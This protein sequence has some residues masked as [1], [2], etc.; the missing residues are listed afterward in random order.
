MKKYVFIIA[1]VFFGILITKAQDAQLS[2]FTSSPLSINPAETGAF[3]GKM[4]LIGNYRGQ[5][6]GF[7]DKNIATSS[8]SFDMPVPSKKI[9]VGLFVANNSA[10]KGAINDLTCMLSVGYSTK[11]SDNQNIAFGLQAGIKQKSFKPE[12]LTFDNQYI[13][14]IGFSDSEPNGE[15]FSTTSVTYPDFNFGAKWWMTSLKDIKPWAGI[16]FYHITKP[17]E[18]FGSEQSKLPSKLI[19]NAGAEITTADDISVVPMILLLSQ[20]KSTQ[21]SIG[22]SFNYE[23]NRETTLI[24]GMYYRSSDALVP[25]AG[26]E[27]KEFALFFDYEINVSSLK[28]ASKNNG[29][30]EITLRYI[31]LKGINMPKY[32]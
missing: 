21:F 19:L 8:F 32:K 15:S 18:S 6:G 26:I 13:D 3:D 23:Q 30:F 28:E 25:M 16:A 31:P 12:E 2:M 22:G 4:R 7:L 29:G 14:G 1:F 17:D 10:T 20:G 5:W 11:I 27:Y 9:G 24:A